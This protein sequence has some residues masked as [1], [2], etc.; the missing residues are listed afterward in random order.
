MKM[1]ITASLVIFGAAILA[2]PQNVRFQTATMTRNQSASRSGGSQILPDG[3]VI[4]TNTSVRDMLRYFYDV[5]DFAISGAPEW[6]TSERYNITAQAAG[7][8]SRDALKQMMRTVLAEQLQ[9]VSIKRRDPCQCS[10]FG[11]PAPTEAW[12][13]TWFL[14]R[15]IV[16]LVVP[17]L[18]RTI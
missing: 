10:Y 15:P 18:A 6:F 2:G 8:P 7:N 14:P 4:I 5:P 9:L 17:L 12:D 11:K 13:Q 16:K 1:P 3:R